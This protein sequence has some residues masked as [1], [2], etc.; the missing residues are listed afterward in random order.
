MMQS[1][2]ARHA[3]AAERG[4]TPNHVQEKSETNDGQVPRDIAGYRVVRTLASGERSDIYL[5][6][7]AIPG[8]PP[9]ALKVF[10]PT[11]NGESIEREI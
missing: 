6:H 7:S 2:R 4:S 10:R 5:G 11:A 9:V 3:D 1:G 8:R